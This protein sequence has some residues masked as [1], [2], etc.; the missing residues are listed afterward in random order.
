MTTP[1][2]GVVIL[3]IL[4]HVVPLKCRA[5]PH[6]L[7]MQLCRCVFSI[8]IVGH[9]F[10]SS[11]VLVVDLLVDLLL[12]CSFSTPRKLRISRLCK[13][14]NRSTS[15]AERKHNMATGHVQCVGVRDCLHAGEKERIKP[16][17]NTKNGIRISRMLHN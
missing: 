11:C 8:V 7:S 2:F 6:M 17:D 5:H 10:L 1:A 14:P 13:T 15:S 16:N 4:N 9:S 3:N 12:K